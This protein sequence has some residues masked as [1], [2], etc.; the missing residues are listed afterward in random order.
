MCIISQNCVRYWTFILFEVEMTEKRECCKVHFGF[1]KSVV[2]VVD[3]GLSSEAQKTFHGRFSLS[4]LHVTSSLINIG[5]RDQPVWRKAP[6]R[7][8]SIGP[9]R[10]YQKSISLP[11]KSNFSIVRF[12]LQCSSSG[13]SSARKKR[14]KGRKKARA[15]PDRVAAPDTLRLM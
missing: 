5:S 14:R 3:R 10:H 4:G 11:G 12:Y 15:P 7:F 2:K 6:G 9:F 13:G 8:Q 1:D